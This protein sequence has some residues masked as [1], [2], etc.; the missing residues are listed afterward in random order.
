MHSKHYVWLTGLFL[1]LGMLSCSRSVRPV[2]GDVLEQLDVRAYEMRYRDVKETERLAREAL[3]LSGGTD[4]VAQ[5]N[6]AYVAYQRMDFD[7]VE[8]ILRKLKGNT[9]NQVYLLCADVMTMKTV[10]RTGDY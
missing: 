9:H 4:D 8:R 1:A 5:L 10:Q 2:Q 7:G 3:R 6:L